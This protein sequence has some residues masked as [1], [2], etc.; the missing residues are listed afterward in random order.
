MTMPK[1]EYT[2]VNVRCDGCN[3]EIEDKHDNYDRFEVSLVNSTIYLCESCQET[4]IKKFKNN[5]Y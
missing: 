5:L 3:N 4:L 2:K 1:E